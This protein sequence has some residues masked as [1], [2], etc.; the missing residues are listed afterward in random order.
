MKT[1]YFTSRTA[2]R[3][4]VKTNGGK[5]KDQGATAVK[6]E[7][8]SVLSQSTEAPVLDAAQY[9]SKAAHARAVL[10]P[11][12]EAN[13]K[14]KEMIEQLMNVVGLTK[15]GARTYKQAIVTALTA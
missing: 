5:F 10:A 3:T 12:V 11:L 6:G 15:N 14:P 8:W 9:K 7:R 4:F 2:A 13:A 1:T